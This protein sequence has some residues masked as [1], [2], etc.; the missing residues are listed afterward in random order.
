MKIRHTLI[1]AAALAAVSP[2]VAQG[3]EAKKIHFERG[4]SGAEV[5]GSITG[6]G[7]IDYK[8][9]AKAGQT[10]NVTLETGTPSQ[11]FNVL[12]PNGGNA[13][14]VGANSDSKS[15][16]GKLPV[17]GEYTIRVYLMGNAKDAGLK[18]PHTLIVGTDGA[19]GG[20][21]GGG[22]LSVDF[23]KE[24]A[25]QGITFRVMT[26]KDD[27][28]DVRL[29]IRPEGLSGDNTRAEVVIDGL[30]TNA[31]VADLNADGSPEVYVYTRSDGA[32]ARGAVHAWSTNNK[33]SMSQI[34]LA[35]P[36]DGDSN[37]AGYRGQDE[38][39]VVENVLARRFPVNGKTRQLQYKLVAGEASWQL[40]VDRVVEF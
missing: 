2:V 30:V 3:I 5:K 24:L 35:T 29:S 18:V 1:L 39:A 14:F 28:G 34:S 16:S 4:A 17:D 32:A 8:L 13:L 21:S 25:L 6:N 36:A 31:E 9:V 40:K 27:H 26:S 15:F 20:G 33:R 12:P 19:S 37:F 11:N 10:M 22:A 38:F 7:A 23:N